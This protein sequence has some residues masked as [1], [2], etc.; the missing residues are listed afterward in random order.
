VD[1]VPLT[2]LSTN[3]CESDAPRLELAL[4]MSCETEPDAGAS[5]T[6]AMIEQALAFANGGEGAAGGGERFSA[7]DGGG[8]GADGA[9]VGETE[10]DSVLPD[11]FADSSF[12]LLLSDEEEVPIRRL[13]L[14]DSGGSLGHWF[15]T[16][17]RVPLEFIT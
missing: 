8:E 14:S 16:V 9:V 1:V 5:C 10:K 11:V 3:N 17:R 12:E 7:M 13:L 15:V 6:A 2:G 4:S